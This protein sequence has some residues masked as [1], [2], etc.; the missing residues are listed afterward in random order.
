MTLYPNC[1]THCSQVLTVVEDI[2]YIFLIVIS[3][4]ILTAV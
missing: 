1:L 3:P 4:D 2:E